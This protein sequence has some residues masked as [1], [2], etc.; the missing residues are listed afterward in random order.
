MLRRL[1]YTTVFLFTLSNNAWADNI[2]DTPENRMIQAERYLQST[3]PKA[4]FE[5][6]AKKVAV[7]MPAEQRQGFIKMMT[8]Q[9]DIDA[10]TQSMKN[11]MV[12]NFTAPEIQ[13]MADYYG[14]PVGKSVMAKMGDYMADVMPV[15]Q[16]ELLKA[17]QKIQAAK[18]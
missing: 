1:I 10:L 11:S 17:F 7:T 12:K 2:A 6:M 9:M 16:K 4:M 5:D 14:S 8:D 15:M 3:P 13:S 18:R